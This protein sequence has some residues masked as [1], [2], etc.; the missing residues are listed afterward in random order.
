MTTDITY[1]FHY[2]RGFYEELGMEQVLGQQQRPHWK[3]VSSLTYGWGPFSGTLTSRTTPKVEKQNR[4][5]H[6]PD[7]TQFDLSTSYKS[8]WGGSFQ[9]GAINVFK[10]QPEYDFSNR[11]RVYTALYTPE[12]TFF[13][14]Y[15]QEF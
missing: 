12:R 9:L 4:L 15:R 10:Q 14:A 2:H 8:P 13:L 3:N 11:L 5:G 7:F 1:L 6:T